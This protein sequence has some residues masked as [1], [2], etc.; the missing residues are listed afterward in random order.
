M[1]S[2]RTKRSFPRLL[3]PTGSYYYYDS[4]GLKQTAT[5]YSQASSDFSTT[6]FGQILLGFT[7]FFLNQFLTLFVGVTLNIVSI[8]LYKTQIRQKRHDVEQLEM[9][10]IHNRPT[11]QREIEQINQRE[12]AE[13]SIEKNMFYM[14]LTLC[15]ITVF[16]RV[17]NI[18]FFFFFN[19]YDSLLLV[20]IFFSLQTFFLVC[21][22]LFS[23]FLMWCFAKNSR[24]YLRNFSVCLNVDI[25]WI[26]KFIF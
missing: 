14:A 26:K 23:I 17:C 3:N 6:L 1:D 24:N 21:P 5:Y 25:F 9:S 22:Y 10:S 19:N 18:Y 16:S 12:R 4:N 15:F 2:I 20:I 7:Q 11:T 13:R 8:Y